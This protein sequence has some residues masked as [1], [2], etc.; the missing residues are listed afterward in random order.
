[1]CVEGSSLTGVVLGGECEF[2]GFQMGG[3]ASGCYLRC[4]CY[5]D[6]GISVVLK[7]GGVCG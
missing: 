4:L 5:E 6:E 7:H 1:M 3:V 2:G